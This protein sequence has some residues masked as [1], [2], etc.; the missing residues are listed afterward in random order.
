MV[1]LKKTWQ[2][3]KT[4]WFLRNKT[5]QSKIHIAILQL[6]V[7]GTLITR[8]HDHSEYSM[9]T[10]W[11][12]MFL[13]K[14]FEE[15]LGVWKI[16]KISCQFHIA[17]LSLLRVI[18]DEDLHKIHLWVWQGGSEKD[19]QW[20]NDTLQALTEGSQFWSESS[21]RIRS[22]CT[23]SCGDRERERQGYKPLLPYLK[24]FHTSLQCQIGS[25]ESSL[26]VRMWKPPYA[27][28]L[29]GTSWR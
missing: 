21:I 20:E 10:L 14:C 1:Y 3:A 11:E 26:F 28:C 22:F 4:L 19:R 25:L 27:K 24:P 17:E 7:N 12:I 8:T 16:L 18:Q 9:H 13:R 5:W 15:F 2:I 6:A 23:Q 29:L